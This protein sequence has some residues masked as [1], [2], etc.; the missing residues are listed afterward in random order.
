MP[1]EVDFRIP[2]EVGEIEVEVE[3]EVEV[4]AEM[5]VP[6]S[7]AGPSEVVAANLHWGIT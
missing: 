7:H 3:V 1:V 2:V 6:S 5:D 4:E